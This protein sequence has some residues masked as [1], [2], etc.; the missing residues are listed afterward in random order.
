M[1]NKSSHL[2]AQDFQPSP[3]MQGRRWFFRWLAQAILTG[4]GWLAIATAISVVVWVAFPILSGFGQ[5]QWF[6]L[7][8]LINQQLVWQRPKTERQ[9]PTLP[10]SEAIV[11]AE[12][13]FRL[14]IAVLDL[15][16][17]V[18]PNIDATD[19]ESYGPALK[20]GVAH[21]KGSAFPGQ[22][23]L[24]YIF[25][26]STNYEWFVAELNA[27]FYQLKDLEPGDKIMVEQNDKKLQYQVRE[28]KIIEADE[29]TF[30]EEHLD[31]DWLV[32][33]T[34]YPPGTTWKRLIVVAQPTAE[35]DR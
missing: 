24:A 11:F 34:C 13:E 9:E 8:T 33:Q 35:E 27:V 10:Q 3:P 16:V 29:T 17:P 14:Q 21:A 4:L 12:E 15:D 2:P 32:L 1:I 6:K 26:H 22:G 7:K 23:K 19:K 30:I 28:K 18:L 20:Q 31:E 5:I 25:G